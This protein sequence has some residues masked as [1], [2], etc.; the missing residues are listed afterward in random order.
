MNEELKAAVFQV[1]RDAVEHAIKNHLDTVILPT[2]NVAS[3]LAA[4]ANPIAIP[5]VQE[6]LRK[7]RE[8]CAAIADEEAKECHSVRNSLGKISAKLIAQDI[9]NLEPQ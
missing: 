3:I 4:L 7:E 9:R 5:G 6:L 8:R 2:G 1:I